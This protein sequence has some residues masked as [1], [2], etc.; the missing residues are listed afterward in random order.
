MV[1]SDAGTLRD[2]LQALADPT[3]SLEPQAA[4]R[5][6]FAYGAEVDAS[7]SAA[8]ALYDSEP[9]ARGVFDRC[10]EV[11]QAERQASLLGAMFDD[12]ASDGAE[13]ATW[14][15]PAT[16]AQQ[17]ALTALW[18]GVGIR[19]DAVQ[20][21]GVGELAAAQ[22]AGVLGL[23]AGLRLAIARARL[24]QD[25]GDSLDADAAPAAFGAALGESSPSRPSIV[26]VDIETGEPVNANATFDAAYWLRRALQPASSG[27]GSGALSELGAD[28]VVNIGASG[29][30]PGTA[31]DPDAAP[32]VIASP[33]GGPGAGIE[34]SE[35]FVRAVA[36]AYE[37]GLDLAF[38]GL[39]AGELRR[40]VG[41]PAYPFQHRRYWLEP[42]RR[43]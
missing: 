38:A 30:S 3:G 29:P 7:P 27:D 34:P 19:P 4:R 8:R 43:G 31:A 32:T 40:R 24:G 22:A 41:I 25:D 33:V 5:V 39:F 10:E 12:D 6:G 23:E 11:F 14:R 17:C 15:E 18:S 16:Y 13:D 35:A 28:V 37:A 42:A 2:G 21:H 36:R 9:V 26:V 20:G 1:F